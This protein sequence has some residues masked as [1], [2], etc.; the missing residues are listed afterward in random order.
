MIENGQPRA[1]VVKTGGWGNLMDFENELLQVIFT[2]KVNKK[3]KAF[4]FL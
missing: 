4:C 3:E 2:G 1:M